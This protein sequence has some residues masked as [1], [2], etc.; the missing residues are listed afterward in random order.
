MMSWWF[1]LV[2]KERRKRRIS[3]DRMSKLITSQKSANEPKGLPI[4]TAVFAVKLD[5]SFKAI[6]LSYANIENE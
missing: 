1:K 3:I 2:S 5:F 4:T 6:V